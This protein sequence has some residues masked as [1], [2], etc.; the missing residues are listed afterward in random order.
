MRKFSFLLAL[1]CLW[2]ARLS[3]QADNSALRQRLNFVFA[4]INK[5]QIPT[6]F[7]AEYG[8]PCAFKNGFPY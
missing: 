3:A 2:G 4:N 6:G 1:L 7:L 8:L 5:S